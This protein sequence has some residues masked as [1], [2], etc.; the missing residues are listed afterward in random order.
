MENKMSKK[1]IIW[2][3]IIGAVVLAGL[4]AVLVY[5]FKPDKGME[6]ET[7][8]PERRSVVQ[9]FDTTGTVLSDSV[10]TFD[11]MA[12]V[13]A[14]QVNVKVGDIVKKGDVLAKFDVTSLNS[15]L[16]VKK[17][18]YDKASKAYNDYMKQVD[19]AK[20][21]VTR[22]QKDIARTQALLVQ[23]EKQFESEKAEQAKQALKEQQE[24]E[25]GLEEI[26][27]DKTLAQ[28]IAEIFSGSKDYSSQLEEYIKKAE[29]GEIKASFGD[30][31]ALLDANTIQY[32]YLEAEVM[33]ASYKVELSAYQAAAKAPLQQ[34]YRTALEYAEKAYTQSKDTIDSLKNG[35]I[36]EKDGIVST[37][38]VTPGVA[39][40]T[41]DAP[42]KSVD[43]A[44]LLSSISSGSMTDV[45]N[46]VAGLLMGNEKGMEVQYYPFK[47]SFVLGQADIPKVALGQEVSVKTVNGGEVK[48][49]VSYIGA[50]AASSTSSDISSILT[51]GGSVAGVDAK[52]E[53]E[54]LSKDIVV[55]LGVDISININKA[56]NVLTIPVESVQYDNE[57]PFV[58][59]IEDK[60]LKKVNVEL[61]LFDGE[62]Y[63]VKSGLDSSSKF[64]KAPTSTMKE[65]DRAY[66]KK[67]D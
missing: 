40:T 13:K 45:K 17:A 34:A 55:G 4:I 1:K 24:F 35:W 14:T 39:Y 62:Y 7:A 59:V 12:G 20:A 22:C 58:Y 48:G 18:D 60:M 53:I 30:M 3:C 61:G 11:L 31:L 66:E 41:K 65:G 23:L 9:T 52:V 10:G 29:N 43:M 44:S 5:I 63:E 21:A 8:S 38:N 2:L 50:V 37:V 25:K 57:D 15:A 56:E 19:D 67:S 33:L 54:T 6:L 47:A 42:S 64:V 51:T 16:A 49:K 46:V 32:K 26:T 36:A 28:K 27:Q